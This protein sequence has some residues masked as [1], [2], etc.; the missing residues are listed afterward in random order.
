[1]NEQSK[2]K[3]VVVTG[4]SS[5]IGKATAVAFA[6][7]GWHVIATGRDPGRSAKAETELQDA[8]SDDAKIDFL[9]ADFCEMAQTKQVAEQ[10]AALADR[11]DVLINN[12]G[13]VRDKRYETSEGLEATMAA[14]HFA[15]FLLTRELLPLIESAVE[16]SGPGTVRI[17]AVS[18]LAHEH[19]PAIRF[20]D[21]NWTTD[22]AATPI[23]S[24]AK[25]A[26]ILFTLELDKRLENKGIVAQSMHPGVVNTNFTT[27]GDEALQAYLKDIEGHPPE[28][29]AETLF[30]MAT[31]PETGFPGARFFYDSKEAQAADQALDEDAAARLWAETEDMLQAIG[32]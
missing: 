3:V 25:L 29:T 24:Q 21:L 1:M 15:P 23:Y 27:H 8:A 28:H 12:A 14:N 22:F 9:V 5:G 20:G 16:E 4:A 18:S 13:G 7:A 30:W 19:C 10:I 11:V 6:R 26:N 2:R 17:L 31:A 32:C